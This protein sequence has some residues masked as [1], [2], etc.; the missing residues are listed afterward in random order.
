MSN[1]VIKFGGYV[2]ISFGTL[3][4]LV[5]VALSFLVIILFPEA[6]LTKKLLIAGAGL[7][8]A[9]IIFLASLAIF[10]LTLEITK[11]EKEIDK[12]EDES[13]LKNT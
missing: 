11:L 1:R 12:L 8:L 3:L 2:V 13:A 7:I 6:N 5:L 10:E 9:V 4:S